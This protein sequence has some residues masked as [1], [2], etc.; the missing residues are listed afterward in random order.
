[1][2][3]RLFVSSLLLT[4]L[5]SRAG[6]AEP[7]SG[8]RP[9]GHFIASAQLQEAVDGRFPMR[10]PVAGML[11]LELQ[12]P[13]LQLLAARNRLAAE[14]PV[15]AA[16]PALNRSHTGSL[17][18]DFALR[19]EPSD[20]SIRAHQLQLGRLSFP[21]LQPAVVELL[22]SYGPALASQALQEVVLHRLSEQDLALPNRMGLQPGSITV[23]ADGLVVA[24]VA[25][26][27]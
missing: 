15:R 4:T 2:H 25:K 13:R 8:A 7:R 17:S 3:R 14:L 26:P 20:R 24:L 11:D 9:P 10:Y 6:A 27:L 12:A 19:F 23:V 5:F 21:T 18:V 1:M 22:N 16:G